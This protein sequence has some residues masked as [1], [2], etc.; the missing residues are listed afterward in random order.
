MKTKAVRMYGLDDL[1]LETF[2][3]PEIKADEILV[4]VIS[5]SVCMSTYKAVKQGKNHKRVPQNVDEHPIIVGHEMAG[6]IEKVGKQYEGQFR[7]GQKFSLQ[8]ALNYKGSPYSP[9]YSYEYFGGNATYNIIP[10]EVMELGCLLVYEGDGFFNASLGE[11]MSCIIGGFHA[12]YHTVPNTYQHI[13]GT[14][15]D[16]NL[17]VL[18]GA[19]PMGL[20]AVEY[21]LA[22]DEKPSKIVVTDISQ[23]R[24]DRAAKWVSPE[25]AKAK[26]V[27]LLYVNTG[28]MADPI[29]DLMTLTDGHGY[30]DVFVYAP[31]VPL[32]EQG[33]KLLAHDG[34][35]NFFAGP[36]D[37]TFTAPINLYNV[38]YSNTHIMGSTGG[39]TNDLIEA[40]DLSARGLINPS[41]M[42]TH[43]GGMDATID[44]IMNLPNIP[45]GKKLIYNHIDLPLTAIEDFEALGVENPLFKTLHELVEKNNGLWNA[46]AEHYLLTYFNVL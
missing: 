11:P 16:G 29:S 25:S 27:E 24:L 28:K 22:I 35:M 41:V 46:E 38:H 19:G 43:I 26:G 17:I 12:S 5:D 20:G 33:D 10:P 32:V 21:A 30:D 14:R 23:D 13:M 8:P 31:I 3:L 36:T 37:K 45:G 44:A 18:G 6:I 7:K 42:L 1:R 4:K 34:C 39:N 2:E 15:P 9:G 40:L